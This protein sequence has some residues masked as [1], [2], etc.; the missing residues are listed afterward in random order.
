MVLDYLV[1]REII[2]PSKGALIWTLIRWTTRI[3]R[4]DT[5]GLEREDQEHCGGSEQVIYA[6]HLALKNEN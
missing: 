5:C 3:E 2:L 4:G 6:Y 1:L